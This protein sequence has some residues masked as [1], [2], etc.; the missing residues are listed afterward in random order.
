MNFKEL[1][2]EALRIK[3]KASSKPD[4]RQNIMKD[5]HDKE[6]DD[7]LVGEIGDITIKKSRHSKEIRDG[8][9]AGRDAGI[10]NDLLLSVFRKLFMKPEFRPRK[11]YAIVFKN[12]KGKWDL[13][14]VE[15]NKKELTIITII[16][17][18]ATSPFLA[19]ASKRDTQENLIIENFIIEDFIVIY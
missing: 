15:L 3:Q 8:D 14:V 12:A 13:M 19:K 11:R 7:Y 10:A 17:K 6:V 16:K 1:F 4:K 2:Q 5:I 9:F 18:N